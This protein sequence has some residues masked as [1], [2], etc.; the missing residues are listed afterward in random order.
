MRKLGESMLLS[1]QR[2]IENC[3]RQTENYKRYSSG[4][5]TGTFVYFDPVSDMNSGMFDVITSCKMSLCI[6]YFISAIEYLI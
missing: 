2:H 1:Y 4:Q 3:R 6:V 5:E